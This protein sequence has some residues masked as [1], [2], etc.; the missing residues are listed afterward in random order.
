MPEITDA[1][2]ME[3]ARY[4]TFGTPESVG[5]KIN[6]LEKDNR[7]Q[8][9]EINGLRESVPEEGQLLISKNDGLEF[10]AFQELGHSADVKARLEAGTEASTK[11]QG[12]EIRATAVSFA[13][14]AGLAEEAVDTLI[15][16]PDLSGA[17][18]EVRKKKNDRDEMVATPYLTLAGENQ[19]AMSFEDAKGKVPV[20]N[21]L[22]A[23][24]IEQPEKVAGT[25]NFVPGG[26]GGG[27]DKGGTIYDKIRQEAENKQKVVQ[28][29]S[30]S[31]SI[32]DRLGMVRTG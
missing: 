25:R 13:Q 1:E 26:G 11:L 2:I 16:I 12:L 18:F 7:K 17:K 28:E 9:E 30:V 24:S 19:V 4:R 29:Q 8:R 14:A 23:A 6:D 31:R 27:G 32:E 3:F 5:K 21:G 22:R 15:A 10:R 20:L